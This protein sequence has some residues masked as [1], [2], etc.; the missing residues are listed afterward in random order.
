MTIN[1][2][3]IDFGGVSSG[4]SAKLQEKD[5]TI[6]LSEYLT[7]VTPDSG[8]D[9]MSKVSVFHSPVQEQVEQTITA[10]GIHKI[11]PETGFDAMIRC[12]VD[13]NVPE[14]I[15]PAQWDGT[16]DT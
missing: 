15:I 3:T 12:V 8:Y 6:L 14:K 11:T 7:E 9:G 1:L 5:V 2:A 4:P 10:N 16:P 13:V